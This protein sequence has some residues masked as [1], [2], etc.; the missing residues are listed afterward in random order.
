[1]GEEEGM[2]IEYRLHFSSEQ[3][4]HSLV[5]KIRD[6]RFISFIIMQEI[7]LFLCR[8]LIRGIFDFWI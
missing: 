7:D 3:A 1:M 5:R 2:R 6:P 8:R 4:Y